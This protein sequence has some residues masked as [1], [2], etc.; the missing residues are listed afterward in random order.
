MEA[1][2]VPLP[3][4]DD[5]TQPID[6]EGEA[7][8]LGSTAE[9]L[10][11]EKEAETAARKEKQDSEDANVKGRLFPR[12]LGLLAFDT[13][14]LGIAP[15]VLKH[16]AEAQFQQGK[17]YYDSA[18]TLFAAGSTISN[19]FGIGGN[20]KKEQAAAASAAQSAAQSTGWGRTALLAGT[21]IATLAGGAAAAYAGRDRIMSSWNWASSHLEFVGC[22]AKEADLKKRFGN[23][24]RLS[25]PG[26]VSGEAGK[27]DIDPKDPAN[28]LRVL[29]NKERKETVGFKVLYTLLAPALGDATNDTGGRTFCR[30]PGE[31]KEWADYWMR[32]ANN[33]VK[34]EIDAHTS[35]FLP[36]ENPQYEVMVELSADLIQ[37]WIGAWQ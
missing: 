7:V 24:V 18:S 4:E 11:E 3:P 21:G 20:K 5:S 9:Q 12:I 22:L 29:D 14:Y 30:V 15:G 16:N 17:Q 6:V 2:Q 28:E 10:S 27:E 37:E 33:K 13:P 25:V 36:E 34:N 1:A 31:K 8:G 23:M 32:A 35:M 19:V 26:D